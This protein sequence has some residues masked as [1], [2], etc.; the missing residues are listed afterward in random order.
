VTEKPT[1]GVFE[2]LAK[3]IMPLSYKDI[4]D[5]GCYLSNVLAV[6]E[7]AL[8]PICETFSTGKSSIIL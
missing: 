3:C 6:K 5:K 4:R 7:G 8:K 1:V 2:A